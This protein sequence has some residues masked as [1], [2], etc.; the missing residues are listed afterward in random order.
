LISYPC[1]AAT[2][3]YREEG[4]RVGGCRR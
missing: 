4:R 2:W 3:Q 1:Q